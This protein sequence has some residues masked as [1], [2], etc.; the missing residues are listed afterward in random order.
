[1]SCDRF[2]D[3]LA[4]AAAG[5]VL[6]AELGA[7]LVGCAACRARLEQQRA[8]LARVDAE[9]RLA[10][11]VEPSLGLLQR[12]RRTAEERILAP[13]FAPWRWLI[14]AAATVGVLVLGFALSRGGRETGNGTAVPTAQS[15]DAAAPAS[16]GP[17]RLD[18]NVPETRPPD[19]GRA[20]FAVAASP[21][22]SAR[23][24]RPGDAGSAVPRAARLAVARPARP[25]EPEVLVPESEAEVFRSFVRNVGLRQ[26]ESRSLLAA[27]LEPQAPPVTDILIGGVEIAPLAV[28]P[29]PT[30]DEPLPRSDS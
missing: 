12:A 27:G 23:A 4:D 9:L 14:P 7:H 30:S 17:V 5:G 16:R 11:D 3:V 21:H 10:L 13:S 19:S 8:L 6:S 26:W 20:P 25:A 24:T 29:L 28:E 2:R 18:P 1:V 22:P 15:T